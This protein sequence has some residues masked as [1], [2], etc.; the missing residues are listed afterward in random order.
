MNKEPLVDLCIVLMFSVIL[1]AVIGILWAAVALGIDI[2]K[3]V[4]AHGGVIEYLTYLF[5]NNLIT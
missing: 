3:D 2:V 1:L 4:I 5:H